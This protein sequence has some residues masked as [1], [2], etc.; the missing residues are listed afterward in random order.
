M[1]LLGLLQLADDVRFK[2]SA[3][4]NANRAILTKALTEAFAKLDGV[5]VTLA[6]LKAGVPAGTLNTIG[7][8]LEDP[9]TAARDMLVERNGYRGVASPVKMSRTKASTRHTPPDFGADN[10]AVLREAGYDEAAIDRL[11]ALGAVVTE[12]REA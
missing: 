3:D 8:V 5:A 12:P 2:T 7:E 4:R 9:Q 10:R 1:A 6:L 11:V